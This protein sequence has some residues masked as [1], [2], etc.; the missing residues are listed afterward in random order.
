MSASH[1]TEGSQPVAA[2]DVDRLLSGESGTVIGPRARLRGHVRDLLDDTALWARFVPLRLDRAARAAPAGAVHVLGLY[3]AGYTRFMERVVAELGQSRRHVTLVL[4]ALDEPDRALERYTVLSGLRGGGK[5][6]NLNA[7]L[8][9]VAPGDARWILAIDDDVELPHGFL[10]RFLFL[11]DRFELQL[12]QP[13]LRHTSHAAWRVCRRERWSV[14]RRTNFV[15]I[16][17]LVAFHRSIASE[18]LPFPPLRMGW[19]LDA[20]WGGLALERGWRLGI[21]D[22]VP[23]RHEARQVASGYD[24]RAAVEELRGFL[25]GRAHIDRVTALEVLERHYGWS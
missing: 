13:A 12:A 10:D 11:A 22:A 21:V 19:G 14:L 3:S 8:K 1:Q 5:F 7:L 20:H 17:P 25:A 6:E 24:R 9:H 4:G 18:L 2:L 23:I 15:E 16:G